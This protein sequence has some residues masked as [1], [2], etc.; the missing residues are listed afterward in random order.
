MNP[1]AAANWAASAS[2]VVRS[3]FFIRY[4]ILFLVLGGLYIAYLTKR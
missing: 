1:T 3:R 2:N 4:I